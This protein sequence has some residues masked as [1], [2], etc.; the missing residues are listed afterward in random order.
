MRSK[1]RRRLRR[2]TKGIAALEA[3]GKLRALSLSKTRISSRSGQTIACLHQLRWL[4]LDE[5]AIDDI[6]PLANLTYLETLSLNHTRLIDAFLALLAPLCFLADAGSIGYG[7]SASA[8]DWVLQT[9]RQLRAVV[10]TPSCRSALAA[11]F[12]W[13]MPSGACR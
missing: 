12:D 13:P 1:L 3:L 11:S 4:L 2:R 7:R 9:V 6:E 10:G 8:R 5:I